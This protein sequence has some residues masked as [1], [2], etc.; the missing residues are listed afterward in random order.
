LLALGLISA[1]G[2]CDPVAALDVRQS[3]RPAPA[4]DCVA[5]ALASSPLVAN[6]RPRGSSAP[7]TY[8]IALRDSAMASAGRSARVELTGA[9]PDSSQ[10][11]LTFRLPGEM[12]WTVG[13][14]EARHLAG[15]GRAI[16]RAVQTA[17]APGSPGEASCRISGMFGTKSC[18]AAG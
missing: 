16:A 14:G 9:S 13:A 4:A 2:A 1:A 6:V 3:L 10:L 12:T 18:D 5:A 7:G 8:D 17:C 11:A 15:L